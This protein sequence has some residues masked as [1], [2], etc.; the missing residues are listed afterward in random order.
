[1]PSCAVEGA[2]RN[3]WPGTW[4]KLLTFFY[5]IS[6]PLVT[7]RQSSKHG[8]TALQE[9]RHL[10]ILIG[11]PHAQFKRHEV[12]NDPHPALKPITRTGLLYWLCSSRHE[13][14]EQ[15]QENEAHHQKCANLVHVP[16]SHI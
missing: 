12:R 6:L 7:C 5:R 15:N 8:R 10:R 11:A 2:L 13:A 14:K 4:S 9:L 16:R 1:M 3:A